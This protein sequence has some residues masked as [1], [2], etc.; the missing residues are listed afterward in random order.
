MQTIYAIH[1]ISIAP[2]ATKVAC[3]S[4]LDAGWYLLMLYLDCVVHV[5]CINNRIV[6]F[7]TDISHIFCEIELTVVFDIPDLLSLSR[8]KKK[9][10]FHRRDTINFAN[11]NNNYYY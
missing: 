10:M 6:C 4:I 8:L 5:I 1:Q 3:F 9:H 7:E 2:S 11:N